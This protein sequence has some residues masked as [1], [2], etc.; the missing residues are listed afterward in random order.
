MIERKKNLIGILYQTYNTPLSRINTLRDYYNTFNK[1]NIQNLDKQRFK[2]IL[3]ELNWAIS[4]P[5]YDFNT[6]LQTDYS[7][8]ELLKW[9]KIYRKNVVFILE[10]YEK[11]KYTLTAQDVP[12]D[13]E[14]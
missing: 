12:R 4:N 11:G 5:D 9:F 3:D 2:N 14:L 8:K 7:N 6:I 10:N 1:V 13:L